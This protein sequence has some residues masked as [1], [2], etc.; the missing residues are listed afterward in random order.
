MLSV[1]IGVLVLSAIAGV[2]SRGFRL[3]TFFL[4]PPA[5]AMRGIRTKNDDLSVEEVVEPPQAPRFRA[6]FARGPGVTVFGFPDKG[7]LYQ[8]SECSVAELD[9]L[10][11]DRFHPTVRPA[12]V[13]SAS[14]AEEDAQLQKNAPAWGYVLQRHVGVDTCTVGW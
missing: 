13:D 10:G 3:P 7:G 12:I 9:F 4:Q 5:N 14:R 1:A 6:E 2:I 8:L 11:L